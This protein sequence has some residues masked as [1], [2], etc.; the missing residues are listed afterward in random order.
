MYEIAIVA[1]FGMAMAI[2]F[3]AGRRTFLLPFIYHKYE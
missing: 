1:G 3:Y 2:G